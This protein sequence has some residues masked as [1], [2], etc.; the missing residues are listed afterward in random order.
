ML[1]LRDIFN[2]DLVFIILAIVVPV[3]WAEDRRR[4]QILEII[5][6][7]HTS[8]QTVP[9]EIWE[10]LLQRGAGGTGAGV[11]NLPIALISAAGGLLF[12]ALPLPMAMREAKLFIAVALACA[13]AAGG[14]AL[15]ARA[16]R[17][18][19]DK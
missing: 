5:K 3:A 11:W 18:D 13:L 2:L 16:R 15:V 8:G 12:A 4:R 1:G 19:S 14:T 17:R 7:I 6:Q 10:R 9:A